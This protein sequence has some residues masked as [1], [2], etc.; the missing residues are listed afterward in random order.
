VSA[1]AAG[2]GRPITG[3][4]ALGDSPRRL[5]LLTWTLAVTEFRLTFM[6]S[7][8][9][10]LWTLMKPLALFGVLFVVFTEFL[11]FNGDVKF[12]AVSL[13]LGII[14][15]SFVREGTAMSVRSLVMRE[16]LVRKVDFPRLAVPMSFI[17]T[18]LF[19][20]LLSLVVVV[21]FLLISGGSVRA[22]WLEMPVLVALLVAFV[23]GLSFLLSTLFVRFRDIE[24]IW[25]VVLQVMFYISPIFYPIE[26][27]FQKA[28]AQWAHLLIMLNPFAAILQQARHA[29]IDPTHMSAAQA[30][31]GTWRLLVPLGI[32]V[33]VNVVGYRVFARNAPRIAEDL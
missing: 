33:A 13:L 28:G 29:F 1:A 2:M 20:L 17:L 25:D 10:Y 9:G 19:N 22:S 31:G 32:I 3:P 16:N 14:L 30:A 6:D 26:L 12:Y 4:T 5:W 23:T 18:A 8:L 21:I 11:S 15:Y 7:F 24:P 27:V